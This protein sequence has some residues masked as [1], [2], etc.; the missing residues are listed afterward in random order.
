M[1]DTGALEARR[2]E[3]RG[4]GAFDT[5]WLETLALRDLNERSG[6]GDFHSPCFA[7]PAQIIYREA[8]PAHG[9]R[10][11]PPKEMR[12]EMEKLVMLTTPHILTPLLLSTFTVEC[13]V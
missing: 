11:S 7:L 10:K 8:L 1:D 9:L 12:I 2:L 3:D 4:E 6:Y 5:R 13:P